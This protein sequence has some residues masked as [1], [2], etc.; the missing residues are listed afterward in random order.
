MKR[1]NPNWAYVDDGE[2]GSWLHIPSGEQT[3][4]STPV[5]K[6]APS[7]CVLAIASHDLV[8]IPK[9]VNSRDTQIIDQIV[10]G[11]VEDLGIAGIAGP[12]KL[13][14]W[15]PVATREQ[16]TLIQIVVIPWPL[17]PLD[18]VRKLVVDYI[19][20]FSLRPPP[21][22]GI[23]LW[24][25][26]N[27]WIAGY[28]RLGE[29]IH[30]HSLGETGKE[31]SFP[32]EIALTV[33]ELAAGDYITEP[34]CFHSWAELPG[35]LAASLALYPDNPVERQGL[36]PVTLS[37]NCSWE[38]L[39]HET[40]RARTRKQNQ[41][42]W[43]GVIS[44]FVLLLAG[45]AIWAWI[46]LHWRGDQN[47]ALAARIADNRERA[48]EIEETIERWDALT[49]AITPDRTAVELF[50]EVSVLLP[51]KGFRLTSFEYLDTRTIILRGEAAS[52]A[53]ALRM[54]SALKNSQQL[55]DYEWEIPTPP[56]PKGNMKI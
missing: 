23:C 56:N 50:H 14:G 8:S 51:E 4:G 22:N 28:S 54:Q 30:V 12:G 11:E 29:W 17:A 43:L 45:L 53:E 7:D 5:P 41:G 25:E 39:P 6:S 1:E 49:P 16:Q 42:K 15:K 40:A 55:A 24:R 21:D 33:R 19:P 34:Q 2:E 32:Q 35:E 47:Q 38:I 48:D 3:R 26:G 36:P 27:K 52:V 10:A 9:W 20:F 31:G 37:E 44:L 46:D 13:Y 18:R